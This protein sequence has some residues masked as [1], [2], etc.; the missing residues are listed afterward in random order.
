MKFCLEIPTEKLLQMTS[1]ALRLL[2][3]LQATV[4]WSA[5]GCILVM[6]YHFC[7]V[8]FIPPDTP[9]LKII[10]SLEQSRHF[11]EPK[12]SL[13]CIALLQETVSQT[14]SQN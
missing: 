3:A 6:D 12:G 1:C 11:T 8:P 7:K 4:S 9:E 2:S 10:S 5:M 13:L 14:A